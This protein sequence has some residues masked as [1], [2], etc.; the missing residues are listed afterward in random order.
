MFCSLKENWSTFTMSIAQK[1]GQVVR[2]TGGQEKLLKVLKDFKFFL[3]NR[4]PD[5]LTT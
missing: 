1:G 4:P 2:W 5:H 3:T